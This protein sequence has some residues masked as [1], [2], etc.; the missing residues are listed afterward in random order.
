MAEDED[1]NTSI[2]VDEDDRTFVVEDEETGEEHTAFILRTGEVAVILGGSADELTRQLVTADAAS[3][4]DEAGSN[5]ANAPDALAT[6]LAVAFLG[7][8]GEDPEFVRDMLN[9]YEAHLATDA[10]R[11]EK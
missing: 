7:R 4:E 1:R 2:E 6:R 3:E 11:D 5:D 10:A 9:W 8:L